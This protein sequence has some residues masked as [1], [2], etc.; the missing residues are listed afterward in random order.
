MDETM[1]IKRTTCLLLLTLGTT[2]AQTA[3]INIS[4]GA[5]YT[6]TIVPHIMEST[7]AAQLAPDSITRL[8]VQQ[9]S[10][11][12][13]TPYLSLELTSPISSDFSKSLIIS[14]DYQDDSLSSYLYEQFR[15]AQIA[16]MVKYH[17]DNVSYSF[18]TGIC[19]KKT[20]WKLPYDIYTG[21]SST[22]S[23]NFGG[24]IMLNDKSKLHLSTSIIG[25]E[26]ENEAHNDNWYE[27]HTISVLSRVG[28][29]YQFNSL[30]YKDGDNNA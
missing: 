6:H 30:T 13:F 21:Y 4:I 28:L 7:P 1:D 14:M 2:H 10:T 24:E 27:N 29:S 12:Y 23:L 20:S 26:I 25:E 16:A 8:L 22:P 17:S 3:P 15:G 19:M 18:G 9:L 11:E 5:G